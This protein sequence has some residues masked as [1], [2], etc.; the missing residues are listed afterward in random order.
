M[1]MTIKVNTVDANDKASMVN[2][3]STAFTQ[4]ITRVGGA[5]TFYQQLVWASLGKK[6]GVE[7][8]VNGLSQAV[9]SFNLNNVTT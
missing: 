6:V 2:S 5:S 9:N 8:S 1:E 3:M 7:V 4:M